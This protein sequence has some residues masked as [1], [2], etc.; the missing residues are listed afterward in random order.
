MK[1]LWKIDGWKNILKG[2]GGKSDATKD[3]YFGTAEVLDE[4]ELTR[5]YMSEGL[6]KKI[7]SR[8]ADDM[9]RNG[10]SIEGD[11]KNKIKNEL[12]R[13]K[14]ETVINTAI[15]W[16]RLYGGAIVVVGAND[17]RKLDTPLAVK[18]IKGID[19]LKVYPASKITCTNADII[20]DP[21]S[22]FFEDFE[23]F[24]IQK[25]GGEP[26][27]VHSTRILAFKG[28]P[29]PD[30]AK[31]VSFKYLYW[32]SSILQS[33]WNQLKNYGAVEQSIVNL[34]MEI[35]IGKYKLSNLAELLSENNTEAIY[36]R[37]EIINASKSI[38]NGVLLGADEEYTRDSVNLTG[39]P[40]VMDRFMLSLSA[41]CE[42]PVTL[43]F[44]RSPAGQNATGESD[45]RNY[46]DMISSKQTTWLKPPLQSL[47]NMING[48]M[49]V[50]TDPI[51]TFNSIWTPTQEQLIEIKKK[52]AETDQIYINTG[53]LTAEEITKNRFEKGYSFE[54]VVESAE[55][56]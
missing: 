13:L 1:N 14:A 16:A 42:I 9:T 55:E 10:I 20:Q 34:L 6:G 56:D 25:I 30:Q 22:P 2:L 47:V 28:D 27:H 3:T 8:P 11:A 37:L 53:V 52:Q 40:D 19:W 17:G 44:G 36:N 41:V 33:I 32:G 12:I 18:G 38:I 29:V 50:T 43:L 31:N 24:Q 5:M 45:L 51:I 49:K 46:Y 26:L 4:E 48:Y 7:I 21:D 23:V 54:T 15:K 39:I 35:V